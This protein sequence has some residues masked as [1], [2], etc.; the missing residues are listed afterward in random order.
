MS[1]RE[2]LAVMSVPVPELRFR[3]FFTW[4]IEGEWDRKQSAPN[5]FPKE[6]ILFPTETEK[7]QI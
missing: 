3:D 7:A 4:G 2:E 6:M 1:H 5:L